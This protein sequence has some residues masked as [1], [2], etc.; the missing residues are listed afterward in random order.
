MYFC[1]KSK[2]QK[3]SPAGFLIVAGKGDSWRPKIELVE[4]NPKV[5][6]I[7]GYEL[8]LNRAKEME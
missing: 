8:H 6:T 7:L 2:P 4:Q 3:F 1:V 5:S